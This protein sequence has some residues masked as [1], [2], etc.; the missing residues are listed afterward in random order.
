M[1][2]P[3]TGKVLS[4]FGKKG[5]VDPAT[6][7]TINE[8]VFTCPLT[9]DADSKGAIWVNDDYTTEMRK[10]D[11]DPASNGFKLER[12]VMGLNIT[13]RSHFFWLP[14][15]PPT[16][17]W[18][19]GDFFVRH[20]AD[21][22]TDGLFTNQRATSVAYQLT[23]SEERCYPHFC[24]VGDHIYGTF[25]DTP[26]V[27]EQVGDGWRTRFALG[28]DTHAHKGVSENAEAVARD[29]GLLA[30]P[31]EPPTDLDKAIA[32]SGDPD[33]KNRPWAWSD[34]NGDGKMEYTKDNP[35]FKIAFGS[36][37]SI[38]DHLPPTTFRSSDGA[39]VCAA[40]D[41]ANSAASLVVLPPQTVNGKVFYDWKNAKVI[42]CAS[43]TPIVDVLAQDGRF[44]V[45]R[46][47]YR[48]V[49]AK[50]SSLECYDES[51]KLLWTRE[52]NNKSLQ[53]LQSLG[54]GMITVMDR[55]WSDIG[56]VMI[57]TKDGDLVNQAISRDGGDC[58]ASGA[59]RADAD[60]GY[61]GIVQAFKITGLATV[62]SA[63]AT[64]NLPRAG[65]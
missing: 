26:N 12:R 2:D 47:I 33:W 11:F 7:G 3:T 38:G 57:R 64:V 17:V 8:E 37:L 34:L 41:K 44:Y 53:N 61:I 40:N 14:D 35:E 55:G 45:L 9:I 13:S 10:Y 30:K 31:G 63:A 15:A 24:K 48:A 18:T 1:I 54:D 52:H 20:E 19:V 36:A 27:Y 60:T 65:L 21:F 6:G 49:F 28:G 22:G 56:P 4:R 46:N 23:P 5:G 50:G 16:Q 25:A 58:W 51:G 59:L 32:A 39:Y 43:G 62:K 42:P 29:A